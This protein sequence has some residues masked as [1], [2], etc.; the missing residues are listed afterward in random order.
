MKEKPAFRALSILFTSRATHYSSEA[1]A[2]LRR[3][4]EACR[5]KARTRLGVF[6]Q[7]SQSSQH[8]RKCRHLHTISAQSPLIVNPG[9]IFSANGEAREA[10]G[11]KR[12]ISFDFFYITDVQ[13]T[14]ISGRQRADAAWQRI[15]GTID[16]N[17]DRI[18]RW[19]GLGFH[20][21]G[22]WQ[23]GGNLGAKIGTLANPSALVSAN[24]TRLE[25][26]RDLGSVKRRHAA[27]K[28][29]RKLSD[30]IRPQW[31]RAARSRAS[32]GES[33]Y[34]SRR[35]VLPPS[36]AAATQSLFSLG[37]FHHF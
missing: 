34:S 17:F 19:Q 29:W 6:S 23:T 27:G 31:L 1:M 30:V 14:P 2:L 24:T 7:S 9:H 12:G 11:Q 8:G 21:T 13:G 16:I 3:C 28:E 5:Q 25:A 18:I 26:V 33:G 35:S 32:T 36:F 10:P 20:A 15:R 4:S 22:V 37:Q